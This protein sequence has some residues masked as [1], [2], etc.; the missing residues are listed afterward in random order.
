V[1]STILYSKISTDPGLLK[2]RHSHRFVA[3]VI[4]ILIPFDIMRNPADV[5]FCIIVTLLFTYHC[6]RCF[7]GFSAEIVIPYFT[8]QSRI[9]I[10]ME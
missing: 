4:Q 8:R 2:I 5:S 3:A 7:N 1:P 9:E 6:T 10:K